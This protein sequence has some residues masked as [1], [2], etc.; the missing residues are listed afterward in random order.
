MHQQH[1]NFLGIASGCIGGLGR[2]FLQVNPAPLQMR[3]I[4]AAFTALICGFM[5]YLGKE[6]Y[7]AIKKKF[8]TK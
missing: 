6:L 3:I 5:G 7:I 2:F 1:N 8:T 4:E